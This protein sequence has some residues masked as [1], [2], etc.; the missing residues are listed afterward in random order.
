MTN[1]NI[2]EITGLKKDSIKNQTQPNYKPFPK[3]LRFAI[4]VFERLN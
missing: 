2:S 3:W 4:Y 1:K